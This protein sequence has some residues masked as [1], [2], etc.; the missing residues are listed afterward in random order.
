[1]AP[2]LEL[3]Y[4]CEPGTDLRSM[5]RWLRLLREESREQ[6]IARLRSVPA[7]TTGS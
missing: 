1:M 4:E 6:V 5:S 7:D 2:W 3:I